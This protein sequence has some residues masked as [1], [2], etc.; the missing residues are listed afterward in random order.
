MTVGRVTTSSYGIS[1]ETFQ[2][3]QR[4]AS[5]FIFNRIDK[6]TTACLLGDKKY[7]PRPSLVFPKQQS[8]LLL[9]I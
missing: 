3:Q 4:K 6:N 1:G 5:G 9:A 8:S 2:D 7:L